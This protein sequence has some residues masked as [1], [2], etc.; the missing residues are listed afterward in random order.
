MCSIVTDV[1]GL[2]RNG[3]ASHSRADGWELTSLWPQVRALKL[4]AQGTSSCVAIASTARACCPNGYFLSGVRV[5]ATKRMSP[6]VDSGSAVH[7]ATCGDRPQPPPPPPPHP[8]HLLRQPTPTPRLLSRALFRSH[9]HLPP[10][11][12]PPS[13]TSPPPPPP[14][15]LAPSP[16]YSLVCSRSLLCCRTLSVLLAVFRPRFSSYSHPRPLHSFFPSRVLPCVFS[17]LRMSLYSSPALSLPS[18]SSL[19][20]RS[21]S[22]FGCSLVFS[23]PR[24]PAYSFFSAPAS[25]C[26]WG[27]FAGQ[28]GAWSGGN[29]VLLS[30]SL[31]RFPSLRRSSPCLSSLPSPALRSRPSLDRSICFVGSSSSPSRVFEVQRCLPT[32]EHPSRVL[33]ARVPWLSSDRDLVSCRG[34]ARSV[35]RLLSAA[36]SKSSSLA[37]RVAVPLQLLLPRRGF[38]ARVANY[39]GVVA[40]LGRCAVWHRKRTSCCGVVAP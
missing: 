25:L 26:A 21:P 11:T 35:S 19:P 34:S 15:L 1:K 22:C 2:W 36:G 4:A 8:L 10:T 3:S 29:P 14:R 37:F 7:A 12:P 20:T 13:P 18:L 24:T 30:R 5:R 9:C 31:S 39:S 38:L 23:L 32:G 28:A 27:L 17:A 33:F 16:A 6:S 40:A